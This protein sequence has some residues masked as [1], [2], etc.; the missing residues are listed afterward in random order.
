MKSSWVL[1]GIIIVAIVFRF[2]W[3][4]S[5]PPGVTNDEASYIYNAY[6]LW[7][8]G[9]DITGAYLPLSINLDNSFSPVPAYLIAPIVGIFGLSAFTGRVLMA[10][11]G[12][13]LVY[14]L[15][16]LGKRISGQES[17]GLAAA[18]VLA[19]MP[20]HV[21]FSRT[22]YEAPLALFFYVLGMYLFLSKKSL[23]WIIVS[24]MC[25]L[26][27]FYS[28]HATKLF[29]IAFFPF[30]LL[31]RY[32]FF[33]GSLRQMVGF[34]L[35]AIAI[36]VS[37]LVVMQYQHVNRG[38]I[39]LWNEMPRIQA[40]VNGERK[41]TLPPSRLTPLFINKG[42]TF[43]RMV[44]ENYLEAY[45]P[46][47]L[48]LYGEVGGLASIYGTLNRGVLYLVELPLLL[49]GMTQ[50][51][52]YVKKPLLYMIFGGFFL[53]GLPSALVNDKSYAV[54][55]IMMIPFL[56]LF[57]GTGISDSVSR[58]KK[59][60]QLPK[61]AV[62]VGMILL[63]GYAIGSYAFQYF[64]RYPVYAAESWFT[65]IRDLYSYIAT[66]EQTGYAIQM[67]NPGDLLIQFA[68]YGKIDPDLVR[69]VYKEPNPKQMGNITFLNGCVDTHGAIFM[70]KNYFP[71][72]TVYITKPE[73][74]KEATPSAVIRDRG[75]Y[76]H[77]LWNIYESN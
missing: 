56:A 29:F 68:F 55:A 66:K 15:Y 34:S 46:Q 8:T 17:I 1:L 43:L 26:L 54:R 35:A 32:H 11:T 27:G 5:V 65:S 7:K 6:S 4:G 49:L 41:L 40:I 74:H 67:A 3:L 59:I 73:C 50:L 12:V 48:F 77:V 58:V 19:V 70:M 53:A 30:L 47:F 60:P 36:V 71:P 22:A 21:H 57:I 31:G 38:V 23:R 2:V 25:F 28:Y 9:H 61:Y 45:S 72:K 10:T 51:H 75:E 13:L 39:F 76:L 24:F 16:L 37:F 42:A 64:N 14:L 63:Y 44:R 69:K 33:K 18:F 20:W 52:R 62:L